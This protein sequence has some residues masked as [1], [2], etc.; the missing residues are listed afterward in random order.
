[1][2]IHLFRSTLKVRIIYNPPFLPAANPIPFKHMPHCK[3]YVSGILV[4]PSVSGLFH[5]S[6]TT[7]AA[8][9][10]A[11]VPFQQTS[12]S[13]KLEGTPLWSRLTEDFSNTYQSCASTA[14]E[15]LCLAWLP[16]VP[17]TSVTRGVF[18]TAE[19]SRRG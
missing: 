7:A 14:G 1:M 11:F 18:V 3:L 2:V 19:T 15:T 17:I 6:T 4:H 10:A 13:C 16:Q 9:T 12:K 8:A 5:D